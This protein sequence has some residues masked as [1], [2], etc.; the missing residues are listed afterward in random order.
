MAVP[1]QKR[2]HTLSYPHNSGAIS[3]PYP[4]EGLSEGPTP[5]CQCFP[6]P[7]LPIGSAP[8]G[9]GAPVL[10][11]AS[12]RKLSL[13]QPIHDPHGAGMSQSE[14]CGNLPDI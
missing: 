8:Q 4:L 3:G 5:R 1:R 13:A 9:G 6:G 12:F 7:I 11:G 2:Q 14:R 10:A